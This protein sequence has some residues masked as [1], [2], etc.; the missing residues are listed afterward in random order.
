[1]WRLKKQ[2]VWGREEKKGGKTEGIHLTIPTAAVSSVV[3]C[4]SHSSWLIVTKA[5]VASSSNHHPHFYVMEHHFISFHALVPFILFS[6]LLFCLKIERKYICASNVYS[7]HSWLLK[8]IENGFYFGRAI[9]GFHWKVLD[10]HCHYI[11]VYGQKREIESNEWT[12]LQLGTE[13]YLSASLLLA[14][15][16]VVVAFIC[17]FCMNVWCQRELGWPPRALCKSIQR[18]SLRRL[19]SKKTNN[20]I[21]MLRQNKLS[22]SFFSNRKRT[23]STA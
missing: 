10:C 21:I 7:K 20:G 12:W 16:V 9:I 6:L 11:S 14:S 8:K 2:Q 17:L 3:E 15:A 5:L 23:A 22:F 4:F 18:P 1:M 19:R 13:P